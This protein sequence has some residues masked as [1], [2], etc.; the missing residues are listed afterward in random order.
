MAASV[1][2]GLLVVYALFMLIIP[3]LISSIMTLSLNFQSQLDLFMSW[4]T[5]FFA[6]ND[7]VYSFLNDAY[8][9]LRDNFTAWLRTSVMPSIRQIVS[10]V[11]ISVLNVLVVLKNVLI[12]V[13]AAVYFLSTRKKF[14][15]QGKLLLYSV[16]RP[17]WADL[18][19]EELAYI[20]R[21]FGGFIIGKIV[22]SAIIGCCAIWSASSPGSPAPC[23]CR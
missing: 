8:D 21:T 1:V 4:V 7:A 23:W 15:A 19:L 20:D 3:Q 12:G 16:F 18:I 10:G 5:R 17:D 9:T 22:D 2:F 11:G 13:I 14:A 6:D